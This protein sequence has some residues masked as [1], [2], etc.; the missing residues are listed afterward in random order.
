MD[1]E[2]IA[3]FV[4]IAQDEPYGTPDIVLQHNP[5]GGWINTRS[6]EIA[7]KIMIDA[8]ERHTCGG[9]NW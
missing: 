8:F 9:N 4:V 6:C 2:K 1:I 7:A 3:E 5:C